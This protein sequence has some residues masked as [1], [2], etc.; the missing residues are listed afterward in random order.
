M[1]S[2]LSLVMVGFVAFAC[3]SFA[4]NSDGLVLFRG[5]GYQVE[6]SLTVFFVL[7]LLLI[8]FLYLGLKIL[9]FIWG[10]K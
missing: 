6:L 4:K 9:S 3:V 5:F 8:G 2:I 7:Q 1:R 10:S